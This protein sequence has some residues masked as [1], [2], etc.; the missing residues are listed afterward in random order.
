[1][2]KIYK[3]L[4]IATGTL[5]AAFLLLLIAAWIW[6]ATLD[7][8]AERARF[9]KLASQV[10][11]REVHIDGALS[12][13]ASVFP[14][15][16][17]AN[18]R[19][20][21]P[22]WA[23]QP[24]FLV[25]N[26]LE[27]AISPW[28]LLRKEIEI[29]DIE[30]TGATLFLQRGPDM[31]TTWKF[32]TETKSGSSRGVIPDIVAMHVK[33]IL[34]VY[35]PF[36]RPPL[37][38]SID[39]LQASFVHDEPVTISAKT[40]LAGIP[41][42]IELLGGNFAELFIPGKRWPFKGTLSTEL[43]DVDYEGYV[44]DTPT[45]NS[46][47]LT[48]S[49]DKQRQRNPL[50]FGRQITPLID[51]YRLDLNIHKEDKT[52]VAKLSGEFYGIDSSRLYEQSQRQ[53]KPA[54]KIQEIK[55]N[56]QSSGLRLGHL[57]Q[58]VTFELTSSDIQY[59][60]PTNA[61]LQKS[62]SVRLDTLHANSR[63]G[64]GFTLL[65]K[66]KV[67]DTPL[68]LRASSKDVLYALWRR[69]EVPLEVDIQSKAAN[70][71]FDGQMARS[72]AGFSL[73]G[74]AS[75][76]SENLA[77]IGELA[78]KK[79]PGS[80]AFLVTSPI[81]FS[82][83]TLTLSD[84][85]C[86]LGSQAIDGKFTLGFANG[87]DLMLKAHTGRF[88]IHNL[89]QQGR[90]P[91][92]LVFGLND[93][94]L[95]VQ[96][97]G[98]TFM[99]SVLGSTWEITASSGRAG[100]KSK[101]KDNERKSKGEYVA[102][103]HDIRFNTHD[104]GSITL[105]AQVTQNEV[106]FKL[107]AQAA[108]LGELLDEVQPY[109]LTLHITG[110]DLS[111]SLKGTVPKP[112]GKAAFDGDLDFKGQLPVIG[113]LIHAKLDREQSVDLHGHVAI[114]H[115]DVKLS[116]VVAKTDGIIVNGEL[117]Y[118]AAK[119]PRLTITSSD[120]SIDLAP[121]LKKKANPVQSNA[122]RR[123]PDARIIPDVSLDFGKLRWLD[124]VVTIKDLNIKFKESPVT[125]INAK[126]TASNGKFRLDPLETRSAINTSTIITKI[127]IDGSK[128]PAIGSFEIQAK[129]FDFGETLKRLGITKEITGTLAMQID[130]TGK[131]KSLR[132]MM[133]T[134]QGN[135]QVVADK[136][137]IP[138]WVLEIWGGGLLRL[139]LPTTWAE[140]SNTVLNCAVAQFDIADGVMRSRTLLADTER[141][142]VAG[143]AVVNWQNE[144]I[145][146]L[147]KPQPKD[148]TLFHLGTPIKL[149]GTLAHPKVGSAQSGLVSLGK[150]A[151]GLTSP[152][153]LIVVFGDVG[154]SEKNPCAALLKERAPGK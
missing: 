11:A 96:G 28:A 22:D 82:D 65:A 72:L 89:T 41:L 68:Q 88:D 123:A 31:E 8:Q 30:L 99:K 37:R 133:G 85:R 56:A 93:L 121:Y 58:S 140:D 74:K 23:E 16:S 126:F 86:Q 129:N 46:V 50:F 84:I 70:I 44:S 71:H 7:L 45:L 135:V 69:L 116:G 87:I 90:I 145:D 61:S 47:E 10:L 4:L 92:N 137:S 79:L 83:R 77:A 40:R 91:D 63:D 103:L 136:G 12:L 1:M 18:L 17:V 64:S 29:R 154:A 27:V 107:D 113:Q 2:K 35:H 76:R 52:F 15:V 6:M 148:A 95:S 153:A 24:D 9:E 134:A 75:V 98:D 36:D 122:N 3:Y 143:E 42:N 110:S 14:R 94:N 53:N 80:A 62:Y 138:K 150:W 60:Y 104:Q 5:L 125:M 144:Q 115:S 57:L 43:Q 131:G 120:S 112:F 124:T 39:E 105:T 66:G 102:L 111:G 142:T 130:M 38:I 128:E 21:N 100:W 147:F 59:R 117:D 108:R 97:K 20:A 149:S 146:G 48:I 25:V 13:R 119:S 81:S 141:V 118:Q 101:P 109:P 19:I 34:I 152:A 55:V 51:R 33:D 73:D 114:A 78:G 151:I 26:Q 67:N 32:K 49:S 132:D 127:E 139:I 54:L 106:Q